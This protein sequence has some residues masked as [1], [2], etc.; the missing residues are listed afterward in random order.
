MK[1]PAVSRIQLIRWVSWFYLWT[2]CL[3]MLVFTRYLSYSEWPDSALGW[4]YLATTV[5]GHAFFLVLL[6]LPL[7]WMVALLVVKPLFLRIALVFITTIG[8]SL[9]VLDSL[10]FDQYRFH[11]NGF[12]ISLL[13]NDKDGQIFDF[14]FSSQLIVVAGVAA[15]LLVQWL[16]SGLIWKKLPQLQQFIRIRYVMPAM[17]LVTFSSH[18]I[19]AYADA[20]YLFDVTKQA[21]FYPVHYPTT[22]NRLLENWGVSDPEAAEREELMRLSSGALNY[23]QQPLSCNKPQQQENLLVI[24]IDTWRYD[25]SDHTTTPNI[26]AFAEQYGTRFTQHYSGGNSTRRGVFSLFYGIP[27]TYWDAMKSTATS[28]VLITELQKQGYQTGIFASAPLTTPAFDKTVFSSIEN[29]RRATNASTSPLRDIKMTDEWLDWVS[30]AKKDQPFFGV[31]FYDAP[32]SYT[33]P[34]NYP[35]I[36]SPSW[37]EINFLKLNNNFDPLPFINRYKNSVHFTDSQVGRVLSDLNKRGLLEN[38]RV[39]ITGDHGQEFNELGKNYWGHGGNYSDYQVRVPMIIAGKGFPQGKELDKKTSH[40]DLV[41]TLMQ[42][43]LGCETA[44]EVYSSGQHL[45]KGKS[46]DWILTGSTTNYGIIQPD[47]I[48]VIYETGMF[49]VVDKRYEPIE[50]SELDMDVMREVMKEQGRFYQ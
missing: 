22:A 20:L 3:I 2:L 40:F 14:S 11:I 48:T 5:P 25:T 44:S 33:A 34:D 1:A 26:A 27:A 31:L 4:G 32:H 47:K 9:L 41:P 28:P 35:E 6:I 39:V 15:I 16:M 21:R 30:A 13:V 49:E 10:V 42:D 36:F 23:P 37:D 18:F 12:I 24:L 38:T 45:L 50:H 19:H 29:L 17:L 7:S 46:R 43:L 8:L